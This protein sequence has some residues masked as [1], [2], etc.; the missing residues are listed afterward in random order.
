MKKNKEKNGI[1]TV[2]NFM[3]I[4]SMF[5]LDIT[6]L[7]QEEHKESHMYRKDKVYLRKH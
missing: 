4:F 6:Y 5:C 2:K 1:S 7:S 3:T